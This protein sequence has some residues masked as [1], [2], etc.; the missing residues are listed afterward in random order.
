MGADVAEQTAEALW[1]VGP[2]RAEIRLEPLGALAPGHVL[3]L[4]HI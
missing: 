3:S 4:I 1:Y 2:G